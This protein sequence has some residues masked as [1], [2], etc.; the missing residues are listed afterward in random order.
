MPDADIVTDPND[1]VQWNTSIA[2]DS[3]G[4][5]H[6]GYYDIHRFCLRQL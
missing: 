2:L 3:I 5:V 6:I 4:K 1:Q